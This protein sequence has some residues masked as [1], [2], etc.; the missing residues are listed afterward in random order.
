M[1]LGLSQFVGLY[2]SQWSLLMAA[3]TVVIIPVIVVF[4]FTQ[5]YFMTSITM[6]GLKG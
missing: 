4:F 6:S 5:R 1:A 2:T 3:A